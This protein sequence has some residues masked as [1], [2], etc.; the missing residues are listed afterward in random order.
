MALT[1]SVVKR[2]VSGN[3]RN[4]IATIT[5]DASYLTGGESLTAAD[6]GLTTITHLSSETAAAAAGT[7]AVV[8]KY[9][10][11]NAKLQAFWTGGVVSTA[12]AQV[13]STTDL[14]AYVCRVRVT[15][16]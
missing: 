5:F 2:N 12:L 16:N 4:V 8:T 7:T 13:T 6:L 1:V 14:S 3:A 15:G 10:Y 9:D 11:T